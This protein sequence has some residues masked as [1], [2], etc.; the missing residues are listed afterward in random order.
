[1]SAIGKHLLVEGSHVDPIH[2]SHTHSMQ[3]L[4]QRIAKA[5]SL[6]ILSTT[7]HQ[8]EPHGATVVLLLSE[9]HLS[10]HT[11]PEKGFFA[12]DLFSCNATTSFE[13]VLRILQESFPEARLESQLLERRVP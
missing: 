5:C 11:W 4:L 7:H 6:T 12:L 9:S 3:D 1:M 13:D 8:F 10:I 2:I